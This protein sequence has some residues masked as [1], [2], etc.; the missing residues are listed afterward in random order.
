MTIERVIV[1]V[2]DGVGVGELPDADEYGDIGS[3]SIANTAR[4]IGGLELPNMQALGLG[5]L[6]DIMGVAP[7]TDTLGAYGKMAEASKGKDSVTGHWELMGIHSP[8]AMPTYPE[9]FPPEVLEEFTRLTGYGVLGNK[10]ASGTEILVELGEEHLK[11]GKLIVY[12]SADSVF[13]I[14]AH[15]GI[16]PIEELYR[17]CQIARDMLSEPH[18]VGRVIARPFEGEPGAFKRTPR[19]HD[20]PLL[21]PSPT[22]MMK[23]VDAGFDVAAVGKIDDLFGNTGI[24]LNKHRTNNKDSIAAMME[25][26]GDAFKGLVLVNLIEY[27]M[28]YGHRNDPQGYA[29]ALRDFDAALPA[30]RAAMRPTDIAMIVADHGVDPTTPST[31]HSREY[32]PLLVFGE[33]VKPGVNLGVRKTFS[34]VGATIAEIFEL[35]KPEIG[36]SFLPDIT[37]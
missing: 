12:T 6:G 7:R 3:N 5:N 9:G 20:Y 14:A 26:V 11:T 21:P 1:I 15:E 31:D 18:A 36:I 13:Q 24:S 10:A 30:L 22:V 25:F 33:P 23:L 32:I 16:V 2:L 29:G 27:D 17:V 8:I 37:W 19:R 4:A 28:I 35:E 34:D